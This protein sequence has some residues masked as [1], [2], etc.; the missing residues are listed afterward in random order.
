MT[1]QITNRAQRALRVA[2][3]LPLGDGAGGGAERDADF[4][5]GEAVEGEPLVILLEVDLAQGV[6]GGL[7]E[8]HLDEL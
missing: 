6:A 8:L 4:H 2:L 1:I 7:V 5:D 3:R